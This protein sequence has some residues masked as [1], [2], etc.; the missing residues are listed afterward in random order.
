MQHPLA[1]MLTAG[2]RCALLHVQHETGYM[3]ASGH[4]LYHRETHCWTR[5]LLV[6]VPFCLSWWVLCACR[7]C[8]YWLR[9]YISPCGIVVYAVSVS[10][11]SPTYDGLCM[12][13]PLGEHVTRFGS[14]WL[15]TDLQML[16]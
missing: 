3:H 11:R 14:S 12:S 16:S 9:W 15:R 2:S 4:Q 5:F 1:C 8:P 6:D 10:H 13:M 7:Q